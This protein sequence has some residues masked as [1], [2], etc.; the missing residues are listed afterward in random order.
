MSTKLSHTK[1][2]I[3]W[4]YIYSEIVPGSEIPIE[5]IDEQQ[6]FFMR[7]KVTRLRGAPRLLART[8]S[9]FIS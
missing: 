4:E 2:R 5:L 8:E 3:H 1:G 6:Q 9:T 7:C